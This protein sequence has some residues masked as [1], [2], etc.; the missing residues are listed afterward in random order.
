M[1]PECVLVFFFDFFLEF[2]LYG[3]RGNGLN[4]FVETE[5]IMLEQGNVGTM[6]PRN[7]DTR[8][9]FFVK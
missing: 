3:E 9:N 1:D 5:M 4:S 8:M 6:R 2:V 7:A